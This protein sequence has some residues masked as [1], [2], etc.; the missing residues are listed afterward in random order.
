[1]EH[2]C[3]STAADGTWA[4]RMPRTCSRQVQ[5]LARAP[6]PLGPI[7]ARARLTDFAGALPTHTVR[8]ESQIALKQ[9]ST[10]ALVAFL[11][12]LKSFWGTSH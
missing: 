8:S 4:L 7:T 1:M 10:P 9:F 6:L 11:A 5:Y 3:G 2:T 12:A